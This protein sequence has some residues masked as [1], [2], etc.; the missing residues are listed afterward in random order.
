MLAGCSAGPVKYQVVGKVADPS[1]VAVEMTF[2]QESLKL[3]PAQPSAGPQKLAAYTLTVARA[4]S[5]EITVEC[6]ACADGKRVTVFGADGAFVFDKRQSAHAGSEVPPLGGGRH[7]D[8]PRGL[9]TFARPFQ[10]GML[11]VTTPWDN[12]SDLSQKRTSGDELVVYRDGGEETA[13][14]AWAGQWTTDRGLLELTQKGNKVTGS[15]ARSPQSKAAVEGAAFDDYLELVVQEANGTQ[16]RALL[17]LSSD[18]EAFASRGDAH[19]WKG[20]RSDASGQSALVRAQ[21]ECESRDPIR[22]RE[23]GDYARRRGAIDRALVLYDRACGLGN[24]TACYTAGQ[25]LMTRDITKAVVYH[26]AGCQKNNLFACHALADLYQTGKGVP[27]DPARAD[28][29]YKKS[30]GPK[31]SPASRAELCSRP[32]VAA[33]PAA[34]PEKPDDDAT[35]AAVTE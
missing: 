22:C 25:T 7:R 21:H 23:L 33:T 32:G 9:L 27:A 15:L 2:G 24:A 3:A 5:G 30:C 10:E 31:V 34:E 18:D 35:P 28:A 12:V 19:G 4:Q 13:P 6:D 8:R 11:R 17:K 14:G 29:L 16:Q 1:K 20:K 26:D